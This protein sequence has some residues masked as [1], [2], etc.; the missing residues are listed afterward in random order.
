MYIEG[1]EGMIRLLR[2]S[3][4]LL[5]MTVVSEEFADR[6]I[7]SYMYVVC[8]RNVTLTEIANSFPST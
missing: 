7:Y 1:T 3:L 2:K 6:C 4:L 8:N 5:R